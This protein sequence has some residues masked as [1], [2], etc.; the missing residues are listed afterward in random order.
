MA[1]IVK[2]G[3]PHQFC[4]VSVWSGRLEGFESITVNM[5]E[6]LITKVGLKLLGQLNIIRV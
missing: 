5:A 2:F 4:K 1:E 6:Q 3:Y